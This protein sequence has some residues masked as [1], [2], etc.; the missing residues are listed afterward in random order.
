MPDKNSIFSIFL[1]VILYFKAAIKGELRFTF[2]IKPATYLICTFPRILQKTKNEN[3][4]FLLPRFR[5][6]AQ[7]LLYDIHSYSFIFMPMK[8]DKIA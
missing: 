1:L 4:A 3:E 5:Y 7:G 8:Y 6:V 2:W